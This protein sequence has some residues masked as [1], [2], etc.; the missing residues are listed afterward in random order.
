MSKGDQ[1]SVAARGIGDAVH[2]C[3]EQA[4]RTVD[5]EWEKDGNVQ[6]LIVRERTR[7]GTIVRE[8]RFPASEVLW[9][10]VAKK[11]VTP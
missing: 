3:A 10:A 8:N 4:G 1:I 7:G 11:E 9:L 5:Y 2:T 6:W